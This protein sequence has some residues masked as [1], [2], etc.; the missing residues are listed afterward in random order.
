V[1]ATNDI[2]QLRLSAPALSARIDADVLAHT[3]AMLIGGGEATCK[4]D[5]VRVTGLSRTTVDTGVQL[6]LDHSVIRHAGLRRTAGRGRSAELLELDPACGYV[7]V[8]DCGAHTAGLRVFDLRQR[9]IAA[10]SVAFELAEGPEAVLGEIARA[11]GELLEPLPH[12][13]LIA[14]IGLPGPV[15]NRSGTVVRPPIM[16]HW[17]GFPI[18]ST[19][20]A[21]LG[22]RVILENDVNLRALGEARA[23]ATVSGPLLYVKVGT[24]IGAGIV[25]SNGE[26]LHGADGSAGDVGHLKVAG[27]D[28]VCVC[29]NRGCL[30]AVASASA[31]WRAVKRLPSTAAVSAR[32]IQELRELVAAGDATVVAELR[33]AAEWV[34]EAVANLVH[35]L[36]PSRVVIGGMLAASSDVLLAIVR[37]VVYQRALPLAT[38]ELTLGAP[39][40]GSSSG[41]AGGLIAGIEAALSP[42]AMGARFHGARDM[43]QIA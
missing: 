23:E 12:R 41:I 39:T 14:V 38:R 20:T 27:S 21:A 40:L 43:E 33:A 15:D 3:L 34:G 8:A 22:C 24:G 25:T 2:R 35:V 16:P 17:D 9:E 31:I 5:L 26:L 36:N 6:L 29:G 10:G 32:D 13:P 4:A 37:S 18:T 11:F 19:L 1:N 28:A 42:D 7:L 30:E